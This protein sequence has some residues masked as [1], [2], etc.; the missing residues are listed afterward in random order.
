M[1]LLLGTLFAASAFAADFKLPENF[2][3]FDASKIRSAVS[4]AKPMQLASV[5]KPTQTVCAHIRVMEVPDDVDPGMVL[6]SHG[7]PE[8]PMP[9]LKPPPACP[10]ND[11]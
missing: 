7:F 1:K 5:R 2:L 11:R 3:V 9:V 4:T 6:P 8:S 10:T